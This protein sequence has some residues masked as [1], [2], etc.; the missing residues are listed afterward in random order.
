MLEAAATRLRDLG[1]RTP[2]AQLFGFDVDESAF[3]YLRRLLGNRHPRQFH[4]QD[5]LTA[6]PKR[7]SVD[8]VIANP[9]F[10][11]YH[12]MNKDQR[13]VI[14]LWR[15]KHRPEFP[16][17]ASLWAYFLCHS[18]SFLGEGGRIAFVLPSAADSADYAHSI[19]SRIAS[20]FDR[21]M[22]FRIRQQ[23]FIQA[24]AEERTVVLLAE[25]HRQKRGIQS[26]YT[27]R[28]VATTDELASFLN[29]TGAKRE[30]NGAQFES[31]AQ[32][33]D[34]LT[35]L[36]QTPRMF[37]LGS[38][39]SVKIGEVI[40]DS[41]FFSRSPLMW[42]DLGIP[43]EYL[44]PIITKTRQAPGLRI[45][46]YETKGLL[47]GIP[48]LLVVD[49]SK[50]TG[51][52]KDLLAKYPTA[53]KERNRT[54]AKRNPWYAISYD[55]SA[56][57]F[58]GSIS[59]SFPR[60]IWNSAGISC[61]N[62]LYKIKLHRDAPYRSAMPLAALTTPFR[63]SAEA[64]GRIRGSGF[65]KLEPS[66]VLGLILPEID[67]DAA[68]TRDLFHRVEALVRSG[69][70]ESATRLADKVLYVDAGILT[71]SELAVLNE[72]YRTLRGERVPF[73]SLKRK[74]PI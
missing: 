5:F 12:R 23:L 49:D 30:Q 44:R 63:L 52:I 9:P 74:S 7:S 66:D 70:M 61:A 38:I 19:L 69:E 2:S 21:I 32:S 42:H 73:A 25:G 34:L 33:R 65:L 36:R 71:A 39:A 27:S 54:F 26:K 43:A 18:L 50:L 48:R 37:N 13:D 57:A 3:A 6:S 24:G 35:K 51:P 67:L 1:C 58:I 60:I 41:Q 47:G 29:M 11:S 4:K 17:N 31:V 16:L 14:G 59:H 56:D 72:A 10:V 22:L 15:E 64:R 45:T 55:T 62:G 20:S 40:G 28:S 68:S 53:A 8:V 46:K